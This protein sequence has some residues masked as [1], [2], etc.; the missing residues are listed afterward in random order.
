MLLHL[1]AR[2]AEVLGGTQQVMLATCGPGDIQA[3]VFPCEARGVRLY[4][5][6]PR[7]SDH[8]FNL[9]FSPDVVAATHSWLLRGHARVLAAG[10][11]PA[12]LHLGEFEDGCRSVMVEV[13]PLRLQIASEAGGP[14]VE[15]IDVDNEEGDAPPWRS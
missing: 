13:T 7:T 8:L 4:V 6:L 1:R 14:Y 5:L 12:G 3:G 2:V 10:L 11:P 15:T 9:E